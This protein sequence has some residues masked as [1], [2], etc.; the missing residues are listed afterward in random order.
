MS[1]D[2]D[3]PLCGLITTKHIDLSFH[4]RFERAHRPARSCESVSLSI[5]RKKSARTF[6][7]CVTE[8]IWL[9]SLAWEGVQR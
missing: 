1:S 9:A 7:A 4:A 5:L 2:V 8:A 6:G 3:A